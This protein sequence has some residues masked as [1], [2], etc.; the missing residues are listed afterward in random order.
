MN[1]TGIAFAQVKMGMET[2]IHN[3]KKILKGLNKIPNY[4]IYFSIKDKK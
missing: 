3:L 4:S 1:S 2:I